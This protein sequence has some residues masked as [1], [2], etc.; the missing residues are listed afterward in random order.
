MQVY[1]NIFYSK[2]L[3]E[4]FGVKDTEVKECEREDSHDFSNESSSSL[5]KT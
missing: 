3:P 5:S 4:G 2:Y 1:Y